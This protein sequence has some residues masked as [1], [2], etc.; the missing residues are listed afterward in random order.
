MKFQSIIE[1]SEFYMKEC[2]NH[3]PKVC[4]SVSHHV[5]TV[6]IDVESERNFGILIAKSTYSPYFSSSPVSQTTLYSNNMCDTLFVALQ[7]AREHNYKIV[8]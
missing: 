4:M 2:I 3:R 6:K 5:D 7:L 8:N 1:L